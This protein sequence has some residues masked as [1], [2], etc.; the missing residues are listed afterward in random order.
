M[1]CLRPALLAKGIKVHQPVAFRD[2]LA[3]VFSKCCATIRIN[4]ALIEVPLRFAA[5]SR[6]FQIPP[7]KRA[8]NTWSITEVPLSHFRMTAL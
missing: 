3:P 1:Y 6:L 2:F 5:D 4:S 8:V 7:G